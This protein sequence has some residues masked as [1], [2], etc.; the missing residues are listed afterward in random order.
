LHKLFYQSAYVIAFAANNVIFCAS[1][2][3]SV[4]SKLL[5][6]SCVVWHISKNLL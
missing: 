4:C 5:Q 3:A 6:I 2:Y 1:W